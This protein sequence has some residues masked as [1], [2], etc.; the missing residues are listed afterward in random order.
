MLAHS[1]SLP[2]GLRSIQVACVSKGTLH[3]SK[4][5]RT[6]NAHRRGISLVSRYSPGAVE[7]V[8]DVTC[9]ETFYGKGKIKKRKKRI[10]RLRVRIPTEDDTSTRHID[11]HR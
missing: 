10:R 1:C 4:A 9:S 3:E 2:P 6:R 11:E 5:R 7:S 8:R